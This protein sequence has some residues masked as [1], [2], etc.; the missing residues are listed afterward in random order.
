MCHVV[1]LTNIT[2]C[3]CSSKSIKYP[4]C[5]TDKL[6]LD[7]EMVA[8]KFNSNYK[9]TLPASI[10]HT[11]YVCV[12]LIDKYAKVKLVNDSSVDVIL[13]CN[14]RCLYAREKCVFYCYN[15]IYL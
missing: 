11:Y 10:G 8:Q 13:L 7:E 12:I 5:V 14:I 2:W 6:C 9:Y 4:W 15:Q 3:L 1:C